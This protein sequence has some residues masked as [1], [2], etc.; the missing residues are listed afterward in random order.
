MEY[1]HVSQEYQDDLI[2][3]AIMSREAEHFHYNFDLQNFQHMLENMAPG[4]PHQKEI[5]DRIASTIRE[6]TKVEKIHAALVAQKPD[7]DRYQA[8]LSRV[9]AKQAAELAAAS[10]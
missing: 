9:Q 2:A 6:M 10:G 8:A 3:Q 1:T 4:D 7:G 5:E